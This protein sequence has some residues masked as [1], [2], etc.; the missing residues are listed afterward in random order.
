MFL[1]C[2]VLWL[3]KNKHISEELFVYPYSMLNACNFYIYGYMV[4]SMGNFKNT[5]T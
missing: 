5:F 1:D 3:V 2:E 4:L